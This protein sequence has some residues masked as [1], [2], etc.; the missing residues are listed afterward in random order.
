MAQDE[1]KK[2][3]LNGHDL[4]F[5]SIVNTD[6]IKYTNNDQKIE[7]IGNAAIARTSFW[8]SGRHIISVKAHKYGSI[9]IGIVDKLYKISDSQNFC[10]SRDGGHAIA[11]WADKTYAPY[12]NKIWHKGGELPLEYKP[13]L[14]TGDIITVDIDLNDKTVNWE[15]N[16]Q[17]LSSKDIATNIPDQVAFAVRLGQRGDCVEI[18]NYTKMS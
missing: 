11:L 5:H 10:T 18:I 17:P 2:Q 16:A 8:K 14:K 13:D 3:Q 9:G 12:N 1:E 4:K 15:V 6:R 7:C